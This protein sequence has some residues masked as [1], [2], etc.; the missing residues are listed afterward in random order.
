M[1]FYEMIRGVS[2]IIMLILV[3]LLLFVELSAKQAGLL[4]NTVII[5]VG[6]NIMLSQYEK[7]RSK[8]SSLRFL[9]LL[10]DGYFLFGYLGFWLGIA[11]FIHALF[12]LT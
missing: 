8:G 7:R 10:K 9:E 5:L 3:G 2:G 12:F 11:L 1:K 6:S 4:F